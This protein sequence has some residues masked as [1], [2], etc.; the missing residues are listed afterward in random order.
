MEKLQIGDLIRELRRNKGMTQDQLAEILDVS[1]PAVC[2]WE[3]GQTYPDIS[4]LP[5]IARYFEVSIDYLFG[6]LNNLSYDKIKNICSDVSQLFIDL[7]FIEAHNEWLNNIKKY[8]N[9]HSLGYELANIGVFNLSKAITEEE[10]HGFIKEIIEIYE[11]CTNSIEVNIKHGSYFQLANMYIVLQD[12]DKAQMMIEKIPSQSVNPQVL[13][14]MIYMRKQDF[15]RAKQNI[16]E[17][18]LQAINNILGELGNLINIQRL[19]ESE[20]TDKLLSLFYQQRQIISI[21]GLDPIY[22]VGVDLQIALIYAQSKNTEKTK[23]EIKKIIGILEKYPQG[24]LRVKDI[25]FFNNIENSINEKS[26]NDFTINSYKIL[27]EQI[28]NFIGNNDDTEILKNRIE[29]L[30]ENSTK[31]T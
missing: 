8:P 31:S 26:G 17:N 3:S 4:M 10:L 29:K 13:L 7:P 28:F 15:N 5:N 30:L 9:N 25:P 6:Y 20:D 11:K 1:I 2:K 22:G 19:N 16:Q 12:F 18:I 27:V 24:K 23:L 21:F 14:S